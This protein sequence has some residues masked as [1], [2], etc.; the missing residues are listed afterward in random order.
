ML[1]VLI[2]AGPLIALLNPNDSRV[3]TLDADFRI[4][5]RHRNK[6]EIGPASTLIPGG[7][8]G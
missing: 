1:T 2:D 8:G 5:R 4:Y 7:H 3:F 6:P